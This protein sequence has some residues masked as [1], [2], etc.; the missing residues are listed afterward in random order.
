[1][2][3]IDYFGE[4]P[5]YFPF[6]LK[7]CKWNPTVNWLIHSD[8]KYAGEVPDNVT[9]NFVTWEDYK[10]LV[11]DRLEIN[12]NPSAAY[13][14][15]DLKPAYGYIWAD[16]IGQ[17]DYWGFGDIDLVYGQIREF[18]TDDILAANELLSVHGWGV[19]GPLCILRNDWK[20]VTAFKYIAGWK[21]LFQLPDCV[22]FDE[23]CFMRKKYHT[24][25]SP[26]E[27]KCYF[28]EQFI[29]PLVKGKWQ[30]QGINHDDTWLWL[31]GHVTCAANPDRKF[32][33]MH[34]MNYVSARY[35]DDSYGK[36]APWIKNGL[37]ITTEPEGGF[38]I[39]LTGI[40][41]L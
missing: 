22:R 38:K 14:I 20:M 11:S 29:T 4:F 27:I 16:E 15:C 25:I 39:D 35:M 37:N 13:K 1:M 17:Y 36:T 3:I 19:S 34:F 21:D 40:H 26:S 6:F 9:L 12:F 5:K 32:I 41:S 31:D 24:D 30:G 7:S 33:C 10:A 18:Y 28:K 8:C 2:I 23:D